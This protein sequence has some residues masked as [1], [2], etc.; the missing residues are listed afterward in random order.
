MTKKSEET[1]VATLKFF[2][3]TQKWDGGLISDKNIEVFVQKWIRCK[4]RKKEIKPY[5]IDDTIW[6]TILAIDEIQ[7]KILLKQK[8]LVKL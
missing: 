4:N 2:L 7:G 3:K 8:S 1:A 5:I 6:T